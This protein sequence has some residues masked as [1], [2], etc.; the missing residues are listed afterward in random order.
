MYDN[1]SNQERVRPGMEERDTRDMWRE[2]EIG[3]Y[4][5]IYMFFASIFFLFLPLFSS[6][7]ED[8]QDSWELEKKIQMKP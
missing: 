8:R 7:S 2:I 5:P 3:T 1:K 4:L 6:I